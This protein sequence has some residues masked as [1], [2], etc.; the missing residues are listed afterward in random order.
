VRKE[1][2][3]RRLVK[4]G[5][6]ETKPL[7]SKEQTCWNALAARNRTPTTTGR[8]GDPHARNYSLFPPNKHKT[9][10]AIRPFPVKQCLC[11]AIFSRWCGDNSFYGRPMWIQFVPVNLDLCPSTPCSACMLPAQRI[12]I[13]TTDTDPILLFIPTCSSS[14]YS[15]ILLP[16]SV[17]QSHPQEIGPLDNPGFHRGVCLTIIIG[18]Q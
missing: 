1:H 11:H 4:I 13:A 12:A 18:S 2:S 5:A 17:G 3:I 15:L 9:R 10:G 8:T 16:R 14:S 6:H 7:E